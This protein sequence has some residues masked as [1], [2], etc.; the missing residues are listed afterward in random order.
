MNPCVLSRGFFV[1]DLNYSVEILIYIVLKYKSLFSVP[2]EC[3]TH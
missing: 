1:E 2:A 3:I